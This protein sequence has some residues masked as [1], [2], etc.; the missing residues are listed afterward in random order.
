MLHAVSLELVNSD[1]TR[2]KQL[3]N[4]RVFVIQCQRSCANPAR[5]TIDT[6]DYTADYQGEKERVSEITSGSRCM[7]SRQAP[8]VSFPCSPLIITCAML[9]CI[10][11]TAVTKKHKDTIADG[12][13]LHRGEANNNSDTATICTSAGGKCDLIRRWMR[14]GNCKHTATY[15]VNNRGT[16]CHFLH[17]PPRVLS[18]CRTFFSQHLSFWQMIPTKFCRT[19]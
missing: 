15:D 17:S 8:A 13:W 14:Y 10:V 16:D 4:S 6:I 11:T 9:A 12:G 19:I 2:Y 7:K 1:P 3:S 18:L 5:R